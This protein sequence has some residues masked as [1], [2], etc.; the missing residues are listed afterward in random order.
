MRQEAWVEVEVPTE[1]Q[2]PVTGALS[3]KRGVILGTESRAGF[4]VIT[5]EVPVAEMVGYSNDLRSMTQ[6]T[7]S[8][9]MEFH[10]VPEAAVAVPGRDR[11][12]GADPRQGRR[13][14]VRHDRWRRPR[15]RPGAARSGRG[16][17]DWAGP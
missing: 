4:S 12:E 3:S 13:P 15:W 1:F 6:G 16:R 14:G 9:S 8:F 17:A 11:Q 10:Q 5:A 2:G 7:G